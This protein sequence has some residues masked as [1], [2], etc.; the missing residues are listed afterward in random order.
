MQKATNQQATNQGFCHKKSM[1]LKEVNGSKGVEDGTMGAA[2]GAA[3]G[4][5]VG[6]D[7]VSLSIT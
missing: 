2:V 6:I 4:E 7:I 1:A 3:V 5:A